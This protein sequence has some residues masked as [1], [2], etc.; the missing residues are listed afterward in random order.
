MNEQ[1]RKQHIQK[2]FNTVSE[3]YDN[4]ALQFF[5]NSANQLPAIFELK[6]DEHLLDIATGTGIAALRLAQQIPHG[7][8]TGIDFSDG[9]L[10]QARNKSAS[11]QLSNTEFLHM[12]MQ[13]IEF[14]D[15][16]FDGANCS[17][18]IF[19]VEDMLGALS[20]I[21]QKVKP[22]GRIVCSSFT[23][24]AF[25][26]IQEIFLDH[27]EEYGVERPQL[28]WKRICDEGKSS[29]LF[30]AAKLKNI[31]TQR[32]NAG[33]HLRDAAQWWDVVWNAG[34][35]GLVSQLDAEQMESFK[36]KHLQEIQKL[37]TNDGIWLDVDVLYTCGER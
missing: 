5:V 37:A 25:Q 2:T 27:M 1:E 24:G 7:K 26:P 4:P 8:V 22:G 9:M 17:F 18:G 16:H 3:G 23:E 33:Y 14:S 12:D 13:A 31:R 20:H 29:E 32:H 10:S 15:A 6:G 34:Y 36:Q 21:A 35:R 28:S 19:F 30:K 11:Q